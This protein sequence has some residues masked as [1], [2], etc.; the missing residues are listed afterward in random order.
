[1]RLVYLFAISVLGAGIL[2]AQA[3]VEIDTGTPE[4]R[5]LQQI[6]LEEDAKQKIMMLEQFVRDH[7]DHDAIKWV[8]GQL[9]PAYA[10]LGQAEQS[11]NWCEKLLAKDNTNA[12]AAHACLKTAEAEKDPD[13]VRKWALL[14]HKAA[15]AAVNAPKPEFEYVEDE[16]EWEESVDYARQVGQYS[17]WALYN[18]ALQTTDPAQK[19]ALMDA[20]E[21]ANP[22]SEHLPQLHSQAFIAYQQSGQTDKAV[23][24]AENLAV[25]NKANG[26]MLLLVANHYLSKQD[27]AKTMEYAQQLIDYMESAETPPQGMDPEAWA[28]KKKSSLGTAQWMIGVTLSSQ[29]QYAKADQ[30]LRKALPNID[31]NQQLLAGALFHLGLANYQMGSKSGNTKQIIAARDY[32]KRCVSFNSPFKAQAQKN[33]D[34]IQAQY[35]FR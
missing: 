21:Q 15:L 16:K 17:E 3:G 4:G 20:L 9:P 8:L 29:G 6:G 19:L 27:N 13:L 31:N 12:P 22:E 33:L 2:F 10:A 25:D 26:D 7:P 18:T 34:A 23:E 5:L 28:N 11:L 32:F 14:T 1:M 35:R 30:T 24:L